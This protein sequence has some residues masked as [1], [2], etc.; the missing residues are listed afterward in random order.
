MSETTPQ[1]PKS[2]FAAR[3]SRRKNA[4]SKPEHEDSEDE[5]S[6]MS[7]PEP[8]DA[9]SVN[10]L[11]EGGSHEVKPQEV[12]ISRETKLAQLNAL[13]DEDMPNLDSMNEQADFS[14]FMSTSVSEGLRKLALRKL[15]HGEAYNVRDGLDEY[16][17]DYTHFEK[18][19]PTTITAD[20]KHMMAVE[21]EKLK[22]LEAEA[23]LED[24]ALDDVD[25][26]AEIAQEAGD[27]TG[28]VEGITEEQ[29]IDENDALADS[30]E[31]VEQL[32]NYEEQ[33]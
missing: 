1:P 30:D 16:D 3:W 24:A 15:F 20:M 19:D 28:E 31:Q 23:A 27:E 9:P 7:D 17:G 18:L 25:D 29:D 13:T 6:L 33:S 4:A 11:Q 10:E 8:V 22:R 2:S 21:E 32:I 26:D 5:V 14:Q 12:D